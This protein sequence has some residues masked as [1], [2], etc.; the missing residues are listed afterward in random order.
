VC[1]SD[2]TAAVPAAEFVEL[3]RSF[4]EMIEPSARTPP[5]LDVVAPLSVPM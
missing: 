2:L 4:I 3:C 5:V 1:S